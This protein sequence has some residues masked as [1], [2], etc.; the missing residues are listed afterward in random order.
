M[1]NEGFNGWKDRATWNIA[2]WINNDEDWYSLSR[3]AVDFADFQ[4]L[5]APTDKTPDGAKLS[6]GCIAEL[7]EVIEDNTR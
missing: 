5:I 4:R 2:L 3:D 7:D 6:E 1:N